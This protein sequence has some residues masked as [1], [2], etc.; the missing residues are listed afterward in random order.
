[1]TAIRLGT[2]LG[3]AGQSLFASSER[4]LRPRARLARIYPADLLHETLVLAER[5][6][7]CLSELHYDY[8]RELVPEGKTPSSHLRSL[9]EA[10]MRRRWPQGAPEKV[11]QLVDHELALITDLNYEAFFLTVYDI[12]EFARARSI[13]CQGRGSAANSAVCYS[14]GI[15]EVDPA[16]MEMLFDRKVPAVSVFSGP[17]YFLEQMGFSK[18]VDTSFMMASMVDENADMGNVQKFFRALRRAQTDIDLHAHRYTHYYKKD[19]PARFHD[20]MDTRLFG[21]GE[22][23]VFEPYTS[24]IYHDTQKWILERGIFEKGNPIRREYDESVAGQAAE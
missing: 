11:R 16:R 15:T 4:Y 14:L 23:I 18:V 20:M 9:T 3:E 6:N 19:F 13:L 10:G 8:P 17:Y 2:T 22:R 21:P 24:D 7:F 12:V 5:C 1:M